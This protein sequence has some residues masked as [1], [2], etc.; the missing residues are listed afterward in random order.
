M[1]KVKDLN[2]NLKG[3]AIG[4]G[5]VDPYIQYPQYATFAYENNLIDDTEY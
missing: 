2:L 1:F 5:W 4:N 3:M